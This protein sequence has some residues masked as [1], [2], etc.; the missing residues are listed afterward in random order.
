MGLGLEVLYGFRVF[1]NPK[2]KSLKPRFKVLDLRVVGLCLER[3]E[4]F[5]FWDGF[6]RNYR[7]HTPK[8]RKTVG[9][10][11]LRG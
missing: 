8:G 4:G 2:H 1:L 3:R 7:K 6:D 5:G 10:I 11:R 9:F